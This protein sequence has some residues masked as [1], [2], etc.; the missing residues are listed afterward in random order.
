MVQI[1]KIMLLITVLSSNAFASEEN[2]EELIIGTW[3]EDPSAIGVCTGYTIYYEDKTYY[4]YGLH[5][6]YNVVQNSDG[7]YE[8]QND[9][10]CLHPSKR[11]YY[12]YSSGEEVD[13]EIPLFTACSIIVS[14]ENRKLTYRWI[15]NS[16]E[17]T[18][19]RFMVKIS[20]RMLREL[21]FYENV[22]SLLEDI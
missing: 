9:I 3:C 5:T 14:Y 15:K 8:I 12:E 17:L 11:K 2:I 22:E 7:V 16:K 1:S 13:L 18:D 4:S 10:G 20:N 19:E 21:P 6:Q